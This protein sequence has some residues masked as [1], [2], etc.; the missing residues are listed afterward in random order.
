VPF[1]FVHFYIIH[2]LLAAA[3]SFSPTLQENPSVLCGGVQ[4][5]VPRP[6]MIYLPGFCTDL[7][8]KTM[9]DLNVSLLPPHL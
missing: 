7:M 6:D 4:F 5:R 3:F 1:Y 8:V 9:T 2:D